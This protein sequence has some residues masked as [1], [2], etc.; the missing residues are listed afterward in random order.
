MIPEISSNMSFGEVGCLL[1]PENSKG[2]CTSKRP[3]IA[4]RTLDP[5]MILFW[6]GQQD[7]RAFAYWLVVEP[8]H[9]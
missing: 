2:F 3:L 9:L 5:V 6:E 8:T 1:T 4:S 7:F